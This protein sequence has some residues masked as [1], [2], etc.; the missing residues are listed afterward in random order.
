MPRVPYLPIDLAEPADIVAPIRKR[1]GGTLL[2]P[3]RVVLHAPEFARGWNAIAQ[4]VRHE[5]SLP[6]KLRELAICAV[7]TLNNAKYEVEKHA[8]EFRK[9]GGSPAQ[10]AALDDVSAAP[11]NTALFDAAERATLQLSLEMT[12]NIEVGDATFAAVRAVLPSDRQVVELVGT[13]G[14]YNMISRV[15]VALHIEKE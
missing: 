10:L 1:R 4:A 2:E 7:G 15:L 13:I 6:A 14:F 3:D 11:R 8:P 5:M 9:A 12:R